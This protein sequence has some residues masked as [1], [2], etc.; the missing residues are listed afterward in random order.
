MDETTKVH[1]VEGP[2]ELTFVA[3][4]VVFLSNSNRPFWTF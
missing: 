3:S 1:R 2:V 4:R